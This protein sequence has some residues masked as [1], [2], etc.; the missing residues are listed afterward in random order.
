MGTIMKFSR[1]RLLHLAAATATL[2]AVARVVRAQSAVYPSHSVRLVVGFPPG[3]GVDLHARLIA[4]WLTEHYGQPFVVENRPG[5]GSN[6]GTEAAIRAPADGYTLLMA[7][8]NNAINATLYSKLNFNFINDTTPVASVDRG[9]LIILVNPS[10]PAKTL[11]E[12]IAYAKANP[13]K[14]NMASAGNGTPSY[15][16]GELFKQMAGLNMLHVPYRGDAPAITDLLGGQVHMHIAGAASVEYVKTGK[17]RALAVGSETRS[18]FLPDVPA[19][20]EFVPGYEGSTWFGVVAPKGT[21]ADIVASLNKTIN[22]GLDDP[23]M[24]ARLADFG[25]TVLKGSPAD[26]GKVIAEETEKW[27]KVVKFSGAKPD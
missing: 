11:P 21:P 13:G 15:V 26:F 16:A 17:L 14:I 3:G 24:K 12:F 22:Q 8:S 19:V 1:R 27:A 10:F 4:Q 20:A 9:L 23:K 25:G 5:A 7:F 18:P 2:P 6:I